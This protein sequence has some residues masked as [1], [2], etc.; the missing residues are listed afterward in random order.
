VVRVAS[1]LFVATGALGIVS[2]ALNWF[3][4]GFGPWPLLV[5]LLIAALDFLL[6]VKLLQLR[7]WALILARILTLWSAVGLITLVATGRLAADPP[8]I[9]LELV[10]EIIITAALAVT[11]FMPSMSKAIPR[12]NTAE[13]P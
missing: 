4:R 3:L 1:A 5:A 11:I 9:R 8:A 12:P 13:S 7:Y 10:I 2:V 6:A